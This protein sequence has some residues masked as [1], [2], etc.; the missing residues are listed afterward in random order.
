MG[1]TLK[2][3]ALTAPV[4]LFL[5]NTLSLKYLSRSGF[6]T[7]DLARRCHAVQQMLQTSARVLF[8]M[9]GCDAQVGPVDRC[10]ESR[11]TAAAQRP[12]TTPVDHSRDRPA[13][14][15]AEAP[16]MGWTVRASAP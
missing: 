7:S 16:S 4:F 9:G 13:G 8:L 14:R 12:T 10:R 6:V 3:A 11:M 2:V 15:G 1:A 5:V